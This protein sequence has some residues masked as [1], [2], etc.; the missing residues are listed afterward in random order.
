MKLLTSFLL[1]AFLSVGCSATS[2]NYISSDQLQANYEHLN[3]EN[4]E[5]QEY[6]RG[7]GMVKYLNEAMLSTMLIYAMGISGDPEIPQ[8]HKSAIIAAAQATD[9]VTYLLAKADI[10]LSEG[11]FSQAQAYLTMAKGVLLSAGKDVKASQE[12]LDAFW[13]AKK[14]QRQLEERSL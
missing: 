8:Q 7:I 3:G 4:E 14:H 9:Y 2:M 6:A 1:V 12:W 5:F 10:E 13:S 11:R